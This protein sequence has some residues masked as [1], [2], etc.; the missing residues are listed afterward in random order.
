MNPVTPAR[1]AQP[2]HGGGIV[3]ETPLNDLS[4]AHR[5]RRGASVAG[6]DKGKSKIGLSRKDGTSDTLPTANISELSITKDW[7]GPEARNTARPKSSG[8][9]A[10]VS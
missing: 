4:N 3:Q 1:R 10:G 7:E 9:G 2:K 6:V 5:D 8:F